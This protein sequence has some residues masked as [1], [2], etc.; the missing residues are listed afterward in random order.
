MTEWQRKFLLGE[1][2]LKPSIKE[3]KITMP[4]KQRKRIEMREIRESVLQAL[5][6]CMIIKRLRMFESEEIE[7]AIDILKYFKKWGKPK[8]DYLAIPV[9]CPKC[10]FQYT[11]GYNIE[12]DGKLIEA[13]DTETFGV[14][15]KP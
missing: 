13:Q 4:V 9:R 8:K 6:D 11:K 1:I 15:Q 2:K 10:G 5:E 14:P 3:G 7:D 12:K